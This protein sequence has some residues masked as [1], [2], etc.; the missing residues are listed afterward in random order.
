M[1]FTYANGHRPL[2]NYEIKRGIGRSTFGEVYFAISD[3]GKEVALKRIH[4]NT[5]IELRGI[6]ECLNLK[7]PHLLHNYDLFVD[8]RGDYWVVMEYVAGQTLAEILAKHPE[9]VAADLAAQWFLGIAGGVQHLWEH[10][11]IHRDLKPANIFVENG[12]VKVGDYGLCKLIDEKL[13]QKHTQ[14]V[15]TVHY[16]APESVHGN[17]GHA[18]D[19][20]SAGVILYEMLTGKVPFD[21]DTAE[22]ILWKHQIGKADLSK[23]PSAF[24]PIL[25]RALRKDPAQRFASI[26]EMAREVAKVLSPRGFLAEIATQILPG[27]HS[28]IPLGPR[29]EPQASRLP[30]QLLAELSGSLL[31][32]TFLAAVFAF[33]LGVLFYKEDWP[34]LVPVFFLA[35]LASAAVVVPAKFWLEP[36]DD[37]WS[38]RLVLMGLGLVLAVA[39]VW[40]DGFQL[41][42][43]WSAGSQADSLRP[44]TSTETARHPFF[45][46]LYPDNRALAVLPGYL[47]FFGLMFLALRWWKI[48]E[49][50][51]PQR[52]S[53][54]AVV[55]T[56]FLAYLLLFLLPAA[57]QR[58][59]GF[60]SL[61]L[62][63]V[64]VQLVSP[65][66]LTTAESKKKLRLDWARG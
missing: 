42:L 39:A 7:H 1:K 41:P 33:V 20:Y 13:K 53:I 38:R 59:E 45:G 63:S 65:W 2:P 62:A 61:V 12:V 46:L 18:F 48:S 16:M 57:P 47:A 30:R 40:F 17:Y 56:A 31:L 28:T 25:D 66:E 14:K 5:E 52:F 32:A 37:S 10:G 3:G 34:R 64:I 19:V 51:R 4:A 49:P 29:P 24:V 55:A 6:K 22:Q 43:P 15:G 50:H 60:L 8:E 36:A 23:V 21:G 11:I 35:T 44:L 26:G 27:L 58:L 9:G 54:K